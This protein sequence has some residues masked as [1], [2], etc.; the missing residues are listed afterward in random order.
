MM[1]RTISIFIVCLLLAGAWTD[2]VYPAGEGISVVD[3]SGWEEIV[4]KG[5]VYLDTGLY[6]E[7]VN[8]FEEIASLYPASAE[9]AYYLGFVYYKKGDMKNAEKNFERA[10]LLD[11]FYTEA[12]YYLSVIEYAKSNYEKVIEYLNKVISLDSMCQSAYYNKGVTFLEMGMPELAIKELAYSLYLVPTDSAPVK[13]ILKAYSALNPQ[14]AEN[15][16]PPNHSPLRGAGTGQE[17]VFSSAD[18]MRMFVFTSSGKRPVTVTDE[19]PVEL[20]DI[21][22]KNGVLEVI[23]TK[24][25][26]LRNASIRFEVK[27]DAG[28]GF[29]ELILRDATAKNSPAFRLGEATSEW[30][31]FSMDTAEARNHLDLECVSALRCEFVPASASAILIRGIEIRA[32]GE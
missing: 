21:E 23:F 25:R 11:P 16:M 20:K 17:T 7:A 18:D 32:E 10:V 2:T 31:V 14:G 8:Y 28:D 27:G 24:P 9:A 26:D 22:G 30:Q 1:S 29:I 5:K 19:N 12:Y 6:G 13:G 3:S 4:S 15:L